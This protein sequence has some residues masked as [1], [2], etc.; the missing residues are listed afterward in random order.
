MEWFR[1]QIKMEV[2][3]TIMKISRTYETNGPRKMDEDNY[4]VETIGRIT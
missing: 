2:G 3:Q 4:R 1:E